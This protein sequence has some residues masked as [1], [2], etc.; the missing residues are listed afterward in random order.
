METNDSLQSIC[1]VRM[2]FILYNKNIKPPKIASGLTIVVTVSMK[3]CVKEGAKGGDKD[4]DCLP[5][6]LR[7]CPGTQP[8]WHRHI[9]LWSERKHLQSV[10]SWSDRYSSPVLAGSGLT[11][12]AHLC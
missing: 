10:N 2:D 8:T 11:A 12:T 9:H 5:V 1:T 6:D 7:R 4:C 3:M